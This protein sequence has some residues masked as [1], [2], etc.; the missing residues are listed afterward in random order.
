MRYWENREKNNV[1]ARRSREARRLKENQVSLRASFLESENVNLRN[2]L[3]AA[4]QKQEDN[5]LQI[6]LMKAKLE[7]FESIRSSLNDCIK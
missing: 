6:Q 3:L 2:K 5:M 1:A 4:E 7:E